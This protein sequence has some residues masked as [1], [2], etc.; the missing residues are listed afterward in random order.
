MKTLGGNSQT[1]HLKG[2]IYWCKL[3]NNHIDLN[4]QKQGV[5]YSIH[6]PSCET[7]FYFLQRRIMEQDKW[8]TGTGVDEKVVM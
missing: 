7:Y 5:Q 3:E 6:R 4:R 8:G 1:V 2:G